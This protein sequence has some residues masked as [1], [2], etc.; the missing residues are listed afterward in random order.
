MPRKATTALAAVLVFFGAVPAVL[1]DALSIYG[2]VVAA[3]TR[4][5]VA[6]LVKYIIPQIS[7]SHLQPTCLHSQTP[8][9]QM[10]AARQTRLHGCDV[11][12]RHSRWLEE[13]GPGA[14]AH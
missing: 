3:V 6:V 1:A 13:Y 14:D 11:R 7:R 10:A 9:V 5:T 8:A 4:L 12:A 2:R